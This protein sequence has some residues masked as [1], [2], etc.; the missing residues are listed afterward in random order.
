MQI[1][2][3][4]NNLKIHLNSLYITQG[5]LLNLGRPAKYTSLVNV[6]EIRDVQ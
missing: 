4:Q 3:H 6:S 2:S 1:L 5:Y